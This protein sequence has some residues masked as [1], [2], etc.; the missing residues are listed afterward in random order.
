MYVNLVGLI[1][2][3]SLPKYARTM[4]AAHC[5]SSS[6]AHD[7]LGVFDRSEVQATSAKFSRKLPFRTLQTTDS[8]AA[9]DPSQQRDR[10]HIERQDPVTGS[11]PSPEQATP[12]SVAI[13]RV[14]F[15]GRRGCWTP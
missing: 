7:I 10:N 12:S 2:S 5:R 15:E 3:Q 9:S 14:A 13:I 4:E 11:S 6:G 8:T 1:M